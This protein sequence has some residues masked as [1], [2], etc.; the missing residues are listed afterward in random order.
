MA[1][2][3]LYFKVH[4]PFSLKMFN[5]KEVGAGVCYED[6]A[7]DEG[8]INNLADECYLPANNIILSA[9]EKTKGAF[10]V[11]FS[12]SGILIDLLER[13]R[14][15][16]IDSFRELT[17][18]GCVEILAETYYHSFSFL[19]SKKEF[20]KQVEKHSALVEQLFNVKPQVFRNTELIYSNKLAEHIAA[21][22]YKGILCEGVSRI[23]EN[24][25]PNKIYIAPG[26]DEFALLLRNASLSDDISFRFDDASWDKHPLTAD[27]FA[28]WVNTHPAETDVINLFMDYETFGIH[29]KTETGIFDFLEA[30]PGEVLKYNNTNFTTASAALDSFTPLDNYDV[31]KTISWEDKT[32]ECCVWCDNMMQNNTLKKIYSLEKMVMYAGD[33][34]LTEVWRRL[35][36][37]DYFYYMAHTACNKNHQHY[38]NPFETPGKVFQYYTNIV[39]DFEISLIKKALESKEFVSYSS[40]GTLY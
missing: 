30:L 29:K 31:P 19:Y 17:D 28:E 40:I 21:L 13:Y 38:E 20:D 8:A 10:K 9:I 33:A 11:N 12:I 5:S 36:A 34:Q 3:S 14:P 16:V 4:H 39:T 7:A 35:Q 24:R 26:L 23:L 32:K 6:V 37:A 15:D 18:T 2:V 25:S 27:K 1:S 22:G